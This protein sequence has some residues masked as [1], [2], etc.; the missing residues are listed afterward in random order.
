MAENKIRENKTATASEK[1]SKKGSGQFSDFI[2]NTILGRDVGLDLGSAT[3]YVSVQGDGVS[4]CEPSV[5]AIDRTTQ[6]IIKVGKEAQEMVGRTSENVLTE[7]PLKDGVISE[8]EV[9][10]RML[11][12]FIRR[13]CGQTLFAP[14]VMISVPGNITDIEERAVLDASAE[15]GA[16]KTYLIKAPI[17]AAM[18]AGLNIK[19]AIGNMIVDIGGGISEIAV[20]S[21]GG[22]VSGKTL[23]VG[24]DHFN[25]AICDYVQ[26]KYNVTIGE[27][28]AEAAKI[29][30]GNVYEHK[31]EQ[32]YDMRGRNSDSGKQHIVTF[33]SKETLVATYE[34]VSALIDGI[35]E[36]IENTRPELVGDIIHNGITLTGGGAKLRGL[37][38]LISE[39]TGMKVN[40]ARDPELCV[41]KG[42]AKKLEEMRK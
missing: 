13:A 37:A 42:T 38:E 33:N 14:K 31:T 2:N 10:L 25:R 5:V 34:P 16:R 9:T 1:T 36:V 32:T 15:A 35:N 29:K 8:Y 11:Q 39:V 6:R 23:S 19:N 22:I 40:V 21:M 4:I 12:Y 27:R 17:A 7:R 18:G 28:T 41:V 24:G 30:V 26:G 3:V 20:V